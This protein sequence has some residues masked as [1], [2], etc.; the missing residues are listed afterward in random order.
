MTLTGLALL[1]LAWLLTTA[2]LLAGLLARVLVLLIVLILVRHS[3]SSYME[4]STNASPCR[5]FR[6][7]RKIMDDFAVFKNPICVRD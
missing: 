4:R 6:F 7:H 3:G 1:L 5:W 2:L